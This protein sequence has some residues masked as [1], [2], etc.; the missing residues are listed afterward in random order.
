M[1]V[2]TNRRNPGAVVRYIVSRLEFP[3]R[4]AQAAAA[5]SSIVAAHSDVA[6]TEPRQPST[7]AARGVGPPSRAAG[8]DE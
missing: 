6:D 4:R 1:R 2:N 3:R 5:P 7:P 8:P